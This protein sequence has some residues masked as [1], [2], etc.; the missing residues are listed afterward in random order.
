M[1]ANIHTRLWCDSAFIRDRK[2]VVQ[3]IRHLVTPR[4]LTSYEG[5]RKTVEELLPAIS[6]TPHLGLHRKL[7]PD[8]FYCLIA[9]NNKENRPDLLGAIRLISQWPYEY[10]K[11]GDKQIS[12]DGQ[13]SILSAK[14]EA[15]WM[16]TAIT[17]QVLIE[18]LRW[19]S[20]RSEAA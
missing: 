6:P 8:F 9:S 18:E 17:L 11:N 15:Y 20:E 14:N 12:K 13:T 1:L 5:L 4:D 2:T 3:V 19:A 16:R 7:D 10:L